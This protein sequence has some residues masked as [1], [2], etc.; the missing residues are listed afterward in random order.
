[1]NKNFFARS[2]EDAMQLI[3]K[4]HAKIIDLDK[5]LIKIKFEDGFFTNYIA[6][7]HIT[8]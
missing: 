1:M 4:L 5:D 6:T 8:Q 3:Y 7:I 2:I